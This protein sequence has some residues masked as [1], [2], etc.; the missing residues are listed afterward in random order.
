MKQ[1]NRKHGFFAIGAANLDYIG[2]ASSTMEIGA[3]SP[4]F[5]QR[6]QGGVALN[7]AVAA[8]QLGF[9]S[10]LI[11]AVGLD[12]DGIHLLESLKRYGVE[13]QGVIKNANAATD[14]YVAIEDNDNLIA[15]IADCRCLLQSE[16]AMLSMASS[17]LKQC[18]TTHG[19]GTIAI[20][21]N[22]SAGFVEE[23]L[24][25]FQMPNGTLAYVAASS[26]KVS[27]A[28][29]FREHPNSM[30]YL[31]RLEAESLCGQKFNSSK[32]AAAALIESG[33]AAAVV[34]N[35]GQAASHAEKH[36][37]LTIEPDGPPPC[38]RTGIGDR[39]AAAHIR[40][41]HLQ[42]NTEEA[43]RFAHRFAVLQTENQTN[44]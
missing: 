37:L 20:D 5:I 15:A 43:L 1:S 38:G 12:A 6:R 13:T 35:S 16:N 2:K 34:T 21:G 22:L 27:T 39:F 44:V 28:V 9:S 42:Y 40:A 31:N 30:L 25:L 29:C 3:D 4:G 23:F 11:S 33:F 19:A 7:L 17:L 41:R 26:E 32:A 14:R 10:N 36:L 8:A 18:R 24:D